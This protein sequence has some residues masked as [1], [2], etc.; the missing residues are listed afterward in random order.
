MTLA[1]NIRNARQVKNLS[2]IEL[3]KML[4]VHQ[5]YIS[6]IERGLNIPT[7]DILD[8]MADALECSVDGLLGRTEN[9]NLEN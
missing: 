8:R 6:Q 7:V 1:S 4:G 2:Q 5:T 3:A 9:K